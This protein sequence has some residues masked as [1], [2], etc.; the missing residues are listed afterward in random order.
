MPKQIQWSA[1]EFNKYQKNKNWLILPSAFFGLIFLWTIISEN[2]LFALLIALSYF[3]IVVYAFKEPRHSK[4]EINGKG[5]KI[6]QIFYPYEN[7]KSFWIFYEP[8]GVKEISL[9]SKKS[10]MPYI[11]VPLGNTNPVKIRRILVK[12]IPERKHRESVIDNLAGFLRF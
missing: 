1:P 5:I 7:L 9:R 11:K 3:L 10:I 4:I 8:S 2:F 6:D 12:Y